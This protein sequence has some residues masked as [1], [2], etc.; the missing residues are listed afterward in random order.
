MI[1]YIED[2]RQMCLVMQEFWLLV[3][4]VSLTRKRW[5]VSPKYVKGKRL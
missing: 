3:S 4:V 2:I 5:Y 1:T